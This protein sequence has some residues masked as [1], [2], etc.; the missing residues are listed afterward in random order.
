LKPGSIGKPTTY[1]G[2]EVGSYILPDQPEKPRWF[3][4]SDKYVKEAVCNVRDWLTKRGRAL[5]SK[6]PTVFPS[7]Y[8]PE[9]DT[10]E[11]SKSDEGNYYQQQIGVLRWMIELGRIDISVEVS[12]LASYAANP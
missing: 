3:V 6:A 4:S 11:Y 8:R 2:A 1:L 9:L 10:T 12:M 5:K 7:G